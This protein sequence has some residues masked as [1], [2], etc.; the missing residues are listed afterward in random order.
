[1]TP[2][3][4][5]ATVRAERTAISDWW[6]EHTQDR[7]HDG[8]VGGIDHRNRVL[9]QANKGIIQNTR[10]LW[11]FSEAARFTAREDEAQAA[12]R[13]FRYLQ[14]RFVDSEHGGVFWEL[15]PQG[16]L[17]NGRKQIYAQAFAIY[18]LSAFYRLTQNPQALDLARALFDRIERFG[19]D[20]QYGGYLEA[21]SRE[22]KPIEDQRLS[23]K[24]LNWPKTMNTHLHLLEA[25]TGLYQAARDPRV[26]EALRGL[27]ETFQRFFIA[28]N[29]HLRSFLSLDWQDKSD[30]VSYGHDIECSWLLWEAG[31]VLED[32]NLTDLLKPLVLKIAQTCLHEGVGEHGEVMDG[33]NFVTGERLT[34]RV[35]WIQAEAMVGFLNAFELSREPAYFAA[36]ERVWEFVCTYQKDSE[37]GEWRWLSS[38]DASRRFDD[39]KVGFW[40]GPYHNGRSMIEVC[41][42]LER[43]TR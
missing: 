10:I 4:L 23:D 27:I 7:Q 28:D 26:A 42:R 19:R 41:Q 37:Y 5:L 36:F 6:L 22:W 18:A 32:A 43:L 17:V 25:Y 40:K 3:A 2:Q 15:N 1:M 35:W 24:D 14:A 12:A 31:R 8:F 34:E 21:F 33:Y 11:Y 16:D 20:H 39:H 30:T 38:L 9:R 29:G 13:A